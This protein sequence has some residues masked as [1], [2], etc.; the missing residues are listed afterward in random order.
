MAVRQYIGARYVPLYDGTWDETKNYEPLTIVDDANGN[1]YTSRR[2]VPAGT[3]LSDR[4]YWI[5]T[6]SFSGA[7]DQLRRDVNVLDGRVDSLDTQAEALSSE[8]EVID[9]RVTRI[10]AGRRGRHVILITDSYGMKTV[11]NF[12]SYFVQY[13]PTTRASAES[14]HGFLPSGGK[15]VDDFNTLISSL[16]AAQ[17]EE[18]SDVIFAGG[19]NDARAIANGATAADLTNAINEAVA[20]AESACPYCEVHVAFIAWQTSYNAQPQ[21]TFNQLLTTRNAYQTPTNT[22][23]IIYGAE[24]VMRDVTNMD[25]TFFH[26]NAAGGYELYKALDAGLDGDYEY[27]NTHVWQAVQ[28]SVPPAGGQMQC[29]VSNYGNRAAFYTDIFESGGS[30]NRLFKFNSNNMPY[31]IQSNSAVFGNGIFSGKYYTAGSQEKNYSGP[32]FVWI[33]GERDVRFAIPGEQP[34]IS[35]TGNA[36]RIWFDVDTTY[37]VYP[38]A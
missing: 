17:K 26:P 19:W 35:H 5:Q 24:S 32:I 38:L 25:E 7:V 28:M 12:V 8:V 27:R 15:F 34:V 4:T 9:E 10:A 1:S 36:V 30:N 21:V 20:A 11:P 22:A 6:S 13:R 14:G 33:D 37:T 31:P 18:I 16:S 23:H 3:T 29:I 2:D